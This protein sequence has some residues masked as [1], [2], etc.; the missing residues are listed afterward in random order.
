MALPPSHIDL[1][2][3]HRFFAGDALRADTASVSKRLGV[4]IYSEYTIFSL[5]DGPN[6][7]KVSVHPREIQPEN[8]NGHKAREREQETVLIGLR[9]G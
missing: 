4:K 7:K 2:A 1:P 5:I 3:T 9:I 6:R 8:P